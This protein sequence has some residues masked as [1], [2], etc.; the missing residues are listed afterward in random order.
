MGFLWRSAWYVSPFMV[1]RSKFAKSG[2]RLSGS[3]DS[4][5]PSPRPSKQSIPPPTE[6]HGRTEPD[7]FLA[8]LHLRL[9]SGN[10]FLSPKYTGSER[11][12]SPQPTGSVLGIDSSDNI[13]N[14]YGFSDIPEITT[15][16]RDEQSNASI[17]EV[18]AVDGE[19]GLGE[20]I[21]GIYHMWKGGSEARG[22]E[23]FIK[24]VKDVLYS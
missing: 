10:G 7:P 18:P 24:I 13:H 21:K 3:G 11:S 9:Q 5:V 20:I 15:R 17:V 2:I 4:T 16:N 1:K 8:N 6:T 19:P 22:E 12:H 14:E 23:E